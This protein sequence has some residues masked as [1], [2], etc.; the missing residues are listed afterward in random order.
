MALKQLSDLKFTNRINLRTNYI[1]CFEE[2][3][4]F[5][6][7]TGMHSHYGQENYQCM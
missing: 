6:Q 7:Q 1:L 2:Q 4:L 5:V 3:T